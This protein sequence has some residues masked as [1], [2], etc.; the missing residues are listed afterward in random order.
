[1]VVRIDVR[2]PVWGVAFLAESKFVLIV[3]VGDAKVYR[4]KTGELVDSVALCVEP[5]KWI[6]VRTQNEITY[7]DVRTTDGS[8]MNHRVAFDGKK[9]L[10]RRDWLPRAPGAGVG[11][12]RCRRRG[13]SW[14]VL[15]VETLTERAVHFDFSALSAGD[16]FVVI[17]D[18]TAVVT[19]GAKLFIVDYVS[20]AELRDLTGTKR[21]GRPAQFIGPGKE[22]WKEGIVTPIHESIAANSIVSWD[23]KSG[24][25]LARGAGGGT[26]DVVVASTGET[27]RTLLYDPAELVRFDGRH[28][29]FFVGEKRFEIQE[30]PKKFERDL[31][32]LIRSVRWARFFLDRDGD[33]FLAAVIASLSC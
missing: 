7:V 13:S 22:L 25:L 24:L 11:R 31:F 6:Y 15:D 16:G 3:S 20:G 12:W 26:L 30:A 21:C 33:H 8:S 4:V 1:M 17:D 28:V 18:R 10:M 32:V 14:F 2:A 23:S 19:L 5:A 9:I 29:G 27:L